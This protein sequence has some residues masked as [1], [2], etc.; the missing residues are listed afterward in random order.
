MDL[1]KN[2]RQDNLIRLNAVNASNASNQDVVKDATSKTQQRDKQ[3]E[4]LWN[5][6]MATTLTP[7][8][9]IWRILPQQWKTYQESRDVTMKPPAAGDFE[10]PSKCKK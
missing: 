10:R 2:H 4:E 6:Y 7:E 3:I 5:K 1:G 8:K 9:R